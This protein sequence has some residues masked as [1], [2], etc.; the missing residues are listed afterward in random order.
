MKLETN[1]YELRFSI[2]QEAKQSLMDR[3]YND[4]EVWNN[5]TMDTENHLGDCPITERPICPSADE[6]RV[7]AE[8]IYSFVQTKS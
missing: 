1:P 3:F 8:K 5:W 6:I 2:W 7:E 4:F